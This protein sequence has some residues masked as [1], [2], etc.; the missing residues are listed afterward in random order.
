MGDTT[1][2]RPHYL[3][4]LDQRVLVFDGAMG[5]SIDTF[6]LTAED[7][8]GPH[9]EGCRDYLVVTRPDVIEQIHTSF[10]EAGCDVLE[11]CSFQSTRLRLAEWGLA[12]ETYNVNYT[13]AALARKVADRFEA[14]DGR[15]RFVAGSMGPTGKL[16]SS[17]DPELSNISFVELVV[18][19]EEQGRALID[20]GADVL[21]IETSQD[22]LEVKAAVLGCKQAIASSA[23]LVALQAQVTLDT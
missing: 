6:A 8:G 18:L 22:I 3:E 5:T 13:A 4:A 10:M 16:P 2:R 11:T 19:Y 23:R 21:L 12:E 7:Y 17:D 1:A 15:S 9:L 14:L 20:G